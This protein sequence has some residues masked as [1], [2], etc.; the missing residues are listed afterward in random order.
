M[1]EPIRLTSYFSVCIRLYESGL[2]DCIYSTCNFYNVWGLAFCTVAL[3]CLRIQQRS[4]E[5]SLAGPSSARHLTRTPS[6]HG[7]LIDVGTSID[8]IKV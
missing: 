5:R 3:G 8:A 4:Q 2:H 6:V 1:G 7:M